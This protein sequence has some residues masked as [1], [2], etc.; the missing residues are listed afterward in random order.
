MKINTRVS[1]LLLKFICNITQ[2]FGYSLIHT[3]LSN[4]CISFFY[5]TVVDTNLIVFTFKLVTFF[6]TFVVYSSSALFVLFYIFK[7][8]SLPFVNSVYIPFQF[9]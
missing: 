4:L 7:A 2:Q 6:G 8:T 9:Y 3:L 1:I 5:S